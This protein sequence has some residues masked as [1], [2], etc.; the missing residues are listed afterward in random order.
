MTLE[1]LF[2]KLKDWSYKSHASLRLWYHPIEGW[3]IS[4]PSRTYNVTDMDLKTAIEKM[5]EQEENI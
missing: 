5:L 1:E 2:Y 4:H 3:T